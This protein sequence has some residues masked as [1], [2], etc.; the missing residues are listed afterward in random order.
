LN[1]QT[2]LMAMRQQCGIRS[3]RKEDT[4]I[5]LLTLRILST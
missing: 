5:L 1:S 4:S 2:K 3:M